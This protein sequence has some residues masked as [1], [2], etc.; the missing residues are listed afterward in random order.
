MILPLYT[1]HDWKP[2]VKYVTEVLEK[3][4]NPSAVDERERDMRSKLKEVIGCDV[5]SDDM[6]DKDHQVPLYDV[7]QTN[8]CLEAVCQSLEEYVEKV[9]NLRKLIKPGGYILCI[10]SKGSKWYTCTG[11]GHKFYVLTMTQEEIE[12]CYENAGD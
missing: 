4:T 9:K 5:M 12:S 8:L 11:D 1:G 7:V 3:N 6:I 10:G 2:Y